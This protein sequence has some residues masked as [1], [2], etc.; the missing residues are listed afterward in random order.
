MFKIVK[1]V[2]KD[3]DKKIKTQGLEPKEAL[4]QALAAQRPSSAE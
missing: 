1:E 3:T 4:K 2:L